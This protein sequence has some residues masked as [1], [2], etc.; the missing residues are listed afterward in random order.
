MTN[1]DTDGTRAPVKK[2]RRPDGTF[3][4]RLSEQIVVDA[5]LAL[6][7]REGGTAL[8][9]RNL[10][11]ELDADPAAMYRYFRTMDDLLLMVADRLMTV[12]DSEI[13]DDLHWKD[14]LLLGGRRVVTVFCLY[15]QIGSMIASRTTRRSGEIAIVENLLGSV[16]AAGLSGSDAVLAYRTYADFVLSYAGMRAQYQSLSEKVREADASSWATV[17]ADLPSGSYPYIAEL[18]EHLVDVD[19][20]EILDNGLRLLIEGIEAMAQRGTRP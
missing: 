14:R 8:T 1:L 15:P 12:I 9:V 17:Y 5:A 20:D 10:G 16:R 19:E 13:P 18:A 7:A 4:P 11:R 6:A 2:L 3:E